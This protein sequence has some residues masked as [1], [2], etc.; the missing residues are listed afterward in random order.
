MK[1][2]MRL[3]SEFSICF[4]GLLTTNCVVDAVVAYFGFW[5]PSLLEPSCERAFY[6]DVAGRCIIHFQNLPFYHASDGGVN[7][8]TSGS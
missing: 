2:S 3:I 7:P 8:Q 1:N 6:T 4:F 5:S